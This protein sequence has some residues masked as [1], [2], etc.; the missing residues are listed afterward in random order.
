[1]LVSTTLYVHIVP[2]SNKNLKRLSF[3]Q[4]LEKRLYQCYCASHGMHGDCSSVSVTK[5]LEAQKKSLLHVTALNQT[6]A[7]S[8]FPKSLQ[9]LIKIKNTGH[10]FISCT[11]ELETQLWK[12]SKQFEKIYICMFEITQELDIL[13]G[14]KIGTK[15]NWSF[16]QSSALISNGRLY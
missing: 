12:E 6:N 16:W 5:Y 10:L 14:T 1:M 11:H 15:V 9:L 7:H 8:N 3:Q 4:S 13:I 2:I